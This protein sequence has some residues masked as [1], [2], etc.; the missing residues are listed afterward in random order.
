MGGG[1]VGLCAQEFFYVLHYKLLCPKKGGRNSRV[2]AS[3]KTHKQNEKLIEFNK[4]QAA[5]DR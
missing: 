2:P 4:E 3:S 1:W 5:P